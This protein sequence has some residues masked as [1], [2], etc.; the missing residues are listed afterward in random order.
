M[1]LSKLEPNWRSAQAAKELTDPYQLHRT[2]ARAF[3]DTL[4]EAR[5]MFRVDADSNDR[6]VIIA[7]SHVEPDWSRLPADYAIPQSKPWEPQLAAG[8]RLSFRLAARPTKRDKSTGKRTS[9]RGDEETMH[10]LRRK[11]A[12]AGFEVVTCRVKELRWKDSKYGSTN[13]SIRS[14][15]FDGILVVTDPDKLREAVRN[16]IGPQKAFG[17]GLLSLAPVR[18]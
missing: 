4:P 3:G 18:E 16:G 1:F 9:L 14:A 7:Q 12:E 13:Q 11:S 5:L 6:P 17:F 2:L 10:W 8:Q 15:V